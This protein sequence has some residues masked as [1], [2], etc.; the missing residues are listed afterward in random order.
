MSTHE[1]FRL[2][3]LTAL[4]TGGASGIGEAIC[5]RFTWSGASVIIADVDKARAQKLSEELEGSSV[6]ELDITNEAAV[7]AAFQKLPKLDIL[8]NNAGVG[9]VASV[10]ET[11]TEDFER[12]FRVNVE[13]TFFVTKAAIP[14]LLKSA[15]NI[16]NIGSVAGVKGFR[17]RFAYCATK[18]AM[19][20]MTKQLALEY[21]GR[22][23]VNAI[24]PGTTDTP[25]V[26]AYIAKYHSHEVEKIR[27]EL[28]A[29]QPVGR[30]GRPDEMADLVLYL[31][32]PQAGFVTGSLMFI[33]GGTMA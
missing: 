28:N 19:L 18:G 4:V 22:I 23:R 29:R 2:D 16:V 31:A 6:L 15:G 30:L 11:T 27:A 8:V 17:R 1:P 25:F 10:E 9:L 5:R 32:S 3:G 12:L 33:D 13:G 7:N 21:A 24:C 26:E 20:A 14:L